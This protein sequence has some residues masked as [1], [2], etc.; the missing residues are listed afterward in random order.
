MSDLKSL[1]VAFGDTLVEV[2]EKNDKLVVLDADLGRST[3]TYA[4]KEKHSD[5]FIQCG[6]A[7]QNMASLS[8]GLAIAGFVPVYS[9]F[10]VFATGRAYDQIRTSICIAKVNVKICGSSSGLSDFGDGKT[11][12]CIDDI[13]LMQSLPNM[14]VLVPADVTETDVLVKE[15]IATDGPCYIRI[16]R[17]D[18]PVLNIDRS[19]FGIGKVQVLAEGS[20]ENVVFSCGGNVHQCL[21]VSEMLKAEG[22][23]LKVVNVASIKPFPYDEVRKIAEKAKNIFIVEE[24][25]TSGAG[26]GYP[27][28]K[29]IVNTQAKV[30]HIGIEDVFGASAEN[31]DVLLEKFNLSSKALCTRMK[32]EISK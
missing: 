23:G 13:S 16:P 22:I 32:S 3:C 19:A 28:F 9:T 15:M 25:S 5:R 29:A 20:D 2:G 18:L 11:H 17:N 27:M 30:S 8:A 31:Y 1:R 24:H 10:A 26:L 7:E 21:E 6:I 4:F 14:K 12:Q